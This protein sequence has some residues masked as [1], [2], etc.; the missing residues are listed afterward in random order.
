MGHPHG[1]VEAEVA[2]VF[3]EQGFS[4][5]SERWTID[6]WTTLTIFEVINE[7]GD[8][9]LDAEEIKAIERE[10]FDSIGDYSYFT[11]ILIDGAP[12][13]IK[14]ATDFKVTLE[15]AKL[16]YSF[17]VPC[18]VKAIKTP[19][20]IK[21][22]VFDPTFYIYV[23][24]ASE[25]GSGIDPTKDPLFRNPAAAANPGDFQRFAAATGLE[26][27]SGDIKVTGP[28]N[29]FT[30]KASLVEE[31]ALAYLQGQIIPQAFNIT[32]SLP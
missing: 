24:Y 3:D 10:S 7:N 20:N 9:A 29:K 26:S 11:S 27:Y 8:G 12:F 14:W 25:A 13:E 32:F 2:L 4:G 5:V 16:I 21:V 1:F 15:G 18:H 17:F 31:P 28:T 6:E 23:A 19:K 22:A 30:I